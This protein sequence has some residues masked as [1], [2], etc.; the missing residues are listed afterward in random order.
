MI[1]RRWAFVLSVLGIFVLLLIMVYSGEKRIES[2]KELESLEV[3]S[4]VIL[5]GVVVSERKFGEGVMLELRVGEGEIME[6]LCDSSG[7]G[8]TDLE[9]K[10][11]EVIG[12]IEEIYGEKKVLAYRMVVLEKIKG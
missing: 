8:E 11:I 7:I 10:E 9:G 3:N 4:K 5:K 1:S 6:V 2:L 12:K